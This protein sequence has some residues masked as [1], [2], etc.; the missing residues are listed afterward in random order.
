MARPLVYASCHYNYDNSAEYAR[1]YDRQPLLAQDSEAV[2]YTYTCRY[3]EKSEIMHKKICHTLHMPEL[4]Y[5]GLQGCRKCDHAYDT[6]WQRH[7]RKPYNQLSQSQKGEQYATLNK[8]KIFF[9]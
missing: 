7:A 4:D 5:T 1:G 8:H 3:E 9:T 6:R 2:H